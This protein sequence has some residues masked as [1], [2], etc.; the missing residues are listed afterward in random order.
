LR[1]EG[2]QR[3]TTMKEVKK[4]KERKEGNAGEAR[5]EEMQ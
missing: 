4:C 5:R 3:R 2:I 1:K